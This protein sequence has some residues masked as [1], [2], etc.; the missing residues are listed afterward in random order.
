MKKIENMSLNELKEE[1]INLAIGAL[2]YNAK[3]K[4]RRDEISKEIEK[5]ELLTEV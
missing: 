3:T 2:V 1:Y 5:R 4:N